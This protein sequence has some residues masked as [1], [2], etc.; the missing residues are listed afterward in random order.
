MIISSRFNFAQSFMTLAVLAAR[1]RF[2]LTFLQ[3]QNTVIRRI[4]DEIDKITQ[5][6]DRRVLVA[7]LEREV[8][9]LRDLSARARVYRLG[10]KNNLDRAFNLS[11]VVTS[12][13]S[14]FST[15]DDDT[16]LTADEVTAINIRKDKIVAALKRFYL[17]KL[18]GITDGNII[19]SLLKN[20][21]DLEGLTAVAGTVDAEGTETPTN[22][23]RPLLDLLNSLQNDVDT[24]AVVT[25]NSIYLATGMILEFDGKAFGIEAK[26][27]SVTAVDVAKQAAEIAEVKQRYANLLSAISLSFEISSQFAESMAKNLSPRRVPPGSI[28]NLFS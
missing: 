11:L 6:N 28:L 2:E 7:D 14:D 27:T 20:I 18:P 25:Q 9:N 26:I 3:M 22:D 17:I 16:N 15:D 24:T 12:T 21:D 1:P 8:I 4:N 13:I 23:N 10:N 5:K 19:Q